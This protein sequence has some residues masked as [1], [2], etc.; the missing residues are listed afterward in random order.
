MGIDPEGKLYGVTEALVDLLEGKIKAYG[1]GQNLFL[2]DIIRLF[3]IK[4]EYG[5]TID[6]ATLKLMNVTLFQAYQEHYDNYCSAVAMSA[7]NAG[8]QKQLRKLL[9]V[10]RDPNQVFGDLESLFWG[11]VE[12]LRA[13]DALKQAHLP[14]PEPSR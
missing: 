9:N 1:D 2:G 14:R 10:A 7:Q 11:L 6:D 5:L 8:T 4:Y 12:I 3:R 13:R